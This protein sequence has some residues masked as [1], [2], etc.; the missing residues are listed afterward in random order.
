MR[1]SCSCNCRDEEKKELKTSKHVIGL[2]VKSKRDAGTNLRIESC[3]D[4]FIAEFFFFLKKG[5]RCSRVVGVSV[6]VEG[7][8]EGERMR[9][10]AY[11]ESGPLASTW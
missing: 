2:C 10:H 6:V 11:S 9:K 7:A 8:D 3:G 4:A 5:A 1:G